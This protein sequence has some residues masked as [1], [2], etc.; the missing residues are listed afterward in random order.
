M[1]IAP[2]I[3]TENIGGLIFG[4]QKQISGILDQRSFD[5]TSS[6][7]GFSLK[8]EGIGIRSYVAHCLVSHEVLHVHRDLLLQHISLTPQLGLLVIV[9]VRAEPRLRDVRTVLSAGTGSGLG[10]PVAFSNILQ[11]HL[12]RDRLCDNVTKLAHIAKGILLHTGLVR[13][14][15]DNWNNHWLLLSHRLRHISLRHG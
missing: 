6:E 3:L 2:G 14:V 1:P 11:L 4:K 8:R 7:V 15:D 13:L 9:E 10:Q 12:A 5:A